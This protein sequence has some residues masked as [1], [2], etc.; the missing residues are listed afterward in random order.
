[1]KRAAL[2]LSMLLLASCARTPM[3][4]PTGRTDLY[5]LLPGSG[6]SPGA[7]VVTSEGQSHT[8]DRPFS[9]AKIEK[10]GAIT[11]G[12]MSEGEVREVFGAALAGQPPRPVSF[13]LYFL[14]DSDTLT[15][16]SERVVTDVLSE[17]ARRP[18]P[19]IVVIGHTDT[20]GTDEYN[21][22]L[23]L[24]RAERIRARLL[25]RGIGIPPDSVAAVG[26]GKRELLVP[27]PDQ[28]TEPRNRRV[29][30]LVK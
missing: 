15:P 16:E 17:I 23:S 18:V 13:L 1:M 22:R 29:E 3:V 20:T 10:P 8:L 24:Q 25:E 6:P 21:D 11:A 12:T 7:L 9:A 30:L 26:R 2:A 14:Q 28:I 4:Q 27:T 5:V 19:E